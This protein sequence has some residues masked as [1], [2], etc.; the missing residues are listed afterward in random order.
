MESKIKTMFLHLPANINNINDYD[1]VIQPYGLA[2]MS[3]FLK[4]HGCDVTLVDAHAHHYTI[5]K[6]FQLIANVR[7]KMLGLP[8]F[9][10]QLPQTI[11]FLKDV[12][13]TFPDI[14]T[15]VGGPH[16]SEEYKSL[17]KYNGNEIDVV[18]IGEAEYTMLELINHIADSKSFKYI[19]GI[20]YKDNGLV[21]V[22]PFRE[23]IQDLDSLPFADWESLPMDR[24]WGA[25]T[26]RKNFANLVFSRG[27]PYSCT[28]CGAKNALGRK[29]RKRSPYNI[30]EEIK[31]LYE[32]H[33]VRELG[34]SDSTFNVDNEW[35]S[36][37]CERI[38]RY[39][40]PDLVWQCNLRVDN[41]DP[42]TLRLMKKS[43]CTKVFVGVESGDDE[44]LKSMK[45]GTNVEMI[46]KGVRLLDEEIGFQVFCGF[47]IGMPG[48]TEGT[49]QKTL[50]LAKEFRNQSNAYSIA[51]PFP[52]TEFYLYA[53]QEGFR[54][55]DW[56]NH[57]TY[58]ITYV[59]KDLTREKLYH[60]YQKTILNY[61]LNIRFLANQMLQL[62]SWLQFIKTFRLGYR[63]LVGRRKRLK[64]QFER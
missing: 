30:M 60:Y 51:T 22:N 62:R 8:V 63:I 23:F 12:K 58:G 25:N 54:V 28:F 1:N 17:L 24:Y 48:E 46:R 29:H 16:P 56:S 59:P 27:C 2:T 55:D 43:G 3:G 7:P 35:V 52:G 38:V 19:K 47:L 26:E 36:E 32:K 15:V 31:V 40:K 34:L 49:I 14:T 6:I 13:K 44:M 39:N 11:S 10:S 42:M 33:H 64:R 37:I 45:K 21:R 57:D 53:Q 18:V 4:H 41:L 61:Y 9:T 20:A 50:A 5:K